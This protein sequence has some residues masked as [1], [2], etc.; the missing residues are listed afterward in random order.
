GSACTTADSSSVQDSSRQ[1]NS[2]LELVLHREAVHAAQHIGQ[3]SHVTT[4]IGAVGG[5]RRPFLRQVVDAEADGRVLDT[6]VAHVQ[7]VLLVRF[8]FG[9]GGTGTRCNVGQA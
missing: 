6:G 2:I 9:Q 8:H 7:V 4:A 5:Q 3:R 1:R